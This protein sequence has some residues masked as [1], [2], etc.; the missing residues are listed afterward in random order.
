MAQPTNSLPQAMYPWPAP[1]GDFI[2][3]DLLDLPSDGHKY[4]I[5]DGGLHVS[6][7]ADIPHHRCEMR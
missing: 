1:G 7:P 5:I 3:D 4:E 6:P 2:A